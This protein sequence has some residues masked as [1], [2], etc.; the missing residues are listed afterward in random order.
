MQKIQRI[1]PYIYHQPKMKTNI[2]K[3]SPN[4]H[5]ISVSALR[6]N[7]AIAG[8]DNRNNR[9]GIGDCRSKSDSEESICAACTC[10]KRMDGSEWMDGLI[11]NHDM[12]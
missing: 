11:H 3:V 9:G 12:R 4:K 10:S 2:K 5:T 8:R 6:T 7:R 1:Q